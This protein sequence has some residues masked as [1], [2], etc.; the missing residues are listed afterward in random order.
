MDTIALE[1]LGSRKLKLSAKQTMTIAEKLYTQG[2]ISYPRTETN[3]F[4]KDINLRAIAEA[5][6]QHP[7]WGQF[8]ERV[9]AWGPNPRNGKKSDEAHPP[10]HP[11]KCANNL[12]GDEKRVYDLVARH[13]LACVSKDAVGSETIVTVNIADEIFTASGLVILERNYL[14]VYPYDKWNAKEVHQYE[15]NEAFVPTTL[16]LDES[17]TSAPK[18]LTEADLIALMDKHGIGTDATHAEH[19]NTIK[20]RGYI[21]EIGNGELMP[22][23]LGMGL[24]EGYEAMALTLA[25]PNLRANLENDLK[26]ICNGR[27]NPA[28]VLRE[29]INIYKEVFQVMT[30]KVESLDQALSVRFNVVPTQSV[31]GE[32]PE[33]LVKALK[34]GKCGRGDLILK[35]TRDG[36]RNYLTCTAYPE[37][38]TSIWFNDHMV[39]DV[40]ICDE[41][42]PRCGDQVKKLAFKFRSL[43][44]VAALELNSTDYTTCVKCDRNLQQVLGINPNSF[45][46]GTSSG[47][48][49]DDN[50]F[51]TPFPVNSTN[52]QNGNNDNRRPPFDPNNRRGRG[53]SGDGPGGAGGAAAIVTSNPH[54]NN[55]SGASTWGQPSNGTS[56]WG[57]SS[58]GSSSWG[59]Q[60]N[61]NTNN[62]S[63]R[64]QPWPNTNTTSTNS[65]TSW[66]QPTARPGAQDDKP[67]PKK[68]INFDI[69]CSKCNEKAT[70]LIVKKDGP[71]KGRQF[72]SCK[73]S[74]NC[75]FFKWA[76]DVQPPPGSTTEVAKVKKCGYCRQPGHTKP[77]CPQRLQDGAD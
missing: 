20:E 5:H 44:S 77:K 22:G 4:S 64:G 53:P 14:D 45:V 76:D 30:A 68:K 33:R 11:T 6:Q 12:T 31:A 75:N 23:T 42:C 27:K 63:G 50:G 69:N 3:K 15:M 35:K 28:D 36:T 61:Q 29:Q 74:A 21:G 60:N 65:A 32:E 66:G 37:C 71:N 19:I 13:F 51:R 9:I 16:A 57:Q 8:A 46:P 24:V 26:A 43:Y 1:K 40:K 62:N 70:L 7:E 73:N 2:F 18:L 67:R 10:I 56:S 39:K 55:N 72:F 34:C 48:R 41:S 38:K 52:N 47:N 58:N 54:N 17:R 25:E 49:N 59:Q